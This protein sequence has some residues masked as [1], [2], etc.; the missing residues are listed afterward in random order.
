MA[1]NYQWLVDFSFGCWKCKSLSFLFSLLQYLIEKL[2]QFQQ[3]RHNQMGNSACHDSK[4]IFFSFISSNKTMLSS[5]FNLG[6][7]FKSSEIKWRIWKPQKFCYLPWSY[8]N[9]FQRFGTDLQNLPMRVLESDDQ[10]Q[11]LSMIW[12]ETAG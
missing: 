11:Q 12:V 4:T 1:Q 8:I 6:S 10:V 9:H 2:F 7:V 3:L 5:R